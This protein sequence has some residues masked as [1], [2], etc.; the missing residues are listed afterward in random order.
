[1]IFLDFTQIDGFFLIGRLQV[2]INKATL[3]WLKEIMAKAE[4]R[5]MDIILVPRFPAPWSY[6]EKGGASW[7][8]GFVILLVLSNT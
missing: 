7:E 3:Y 1:M 4:T 8:V 2:N 5:F 6:V